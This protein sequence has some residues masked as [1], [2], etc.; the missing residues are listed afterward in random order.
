M[1]TELEPV[2]Y[3]DAFQY[4]E[5]KFEKISVPVSAEYGV[6][7]AINGKTFVS[8]AC[9]G[10]QLKE[11]GAGFL[12]AEGILHHKDEIE[13]IVV[14][15]EKLFVNIKIKESDAIVS[16]LFSIRSIVSGCGNVSLGSTM[17]QKLHPPQVSPEMILKIG[18]QFY[19]TSE[20]H[21]LTHGVHSAGLY[22]RSGECIAFYDEI[23]RHSAIDKLVGYALFNDIQLDDKIVYSTGRISS[24]IVQKAIASGFSIIATKGSPTSLAV[25]LANEY[26]VV[27]IAKVRINRFS[28]FTTSIN[29][30][31]IFGIG[32]KY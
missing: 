27:L 26:N 8:I 2:K 32:V 28:V 19:Q 24:E 14:D 6:S 16:R 20:L 15:F 4:Q 17:I 23:G 13:D 5:G 29:Y 30:E 3:V 21:K 9:S 11:L 10:E 18:K 7:I 12:V 31:S 22:T 25:Q 1:D